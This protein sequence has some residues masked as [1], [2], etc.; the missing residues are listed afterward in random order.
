MTRLRAQLFTLTRDTHSQ[1]IQDWREGDGPLLRGIVG[2]VVRLNEKTVLL[3]E[4][5]R[6]LAHVV[7]PREWGA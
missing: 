1:P 2:H 6:Q 5:Q 3:H 4:L 7:R